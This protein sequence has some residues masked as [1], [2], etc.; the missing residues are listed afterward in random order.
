MKKKG[1]V[2]NVQKPSTGLKQNDSDCLTHK[3]PRPLVEAIEGVNVESGQ[4]QTASF[5]GFSA[6][7]ILHVADVDNTH[8]KREKKA[9]K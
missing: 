6:W 7:D 1:D 9:S 5:Y 8:G 2:K 3:T 4:R